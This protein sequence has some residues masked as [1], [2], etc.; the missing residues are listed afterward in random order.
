MIE[1]EVQNFQAI[2]HATMAVDGFAAIVGRSNIGKSAIVRA[3][4]IALTGAIG[5]DFVRHGQECD[6]KIRQTK[7]CKCFSKVVIR[8]S[9]MEITWEKGDAVS[10]YTVKRSGTEP[11]VYEGLERGTPE[12]LKEGFLPVKIGTRKELIQIPDQFEPIFLLN[13]SG[14]AVADVLSDVARLDA[15]N[16]AMGDANRDRK[17]A[18]SKRKVR[19]GDVAAL[20]EALAL[21]EGLDRVAVDSLVRDLK[22]A[23]TKN[24]QLSQ[25][26]GFI[27]R[28]GLLKTTMV[29]LDAVLKPELPDNDQLGEKGNQLVQVSE[30]YTALSEKVPGLRALA[31]M[32]KVEV[33]DEAPLD[34]THD[35]LLQ[36]DSFLRRLNALTVAEA[37]LAPAQHIDVPDGGA[38]G[39]TLI[40]LDK[41]DHW[42]KK[43]EA[44]EAALARVPTIAELPDFDLLQQKLTECL[45]Y[46]TLLED[47][48][49][50]AEVV[51]STATQIKEAEADETALLA[52]LEALGVCP[53]CDQPVGHSHRLHMEAQ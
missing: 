1:L 38:A 27:D 11:E 51:K 46:H 49:A 37:E 6:R 24:K 47:A 20:V 26:S 44:V 12:F 35:R 8:T 21:Y 52:E 23:G 3:A 34:T 13:Q 22:V 45:R 53:T 10:R 43:L 33:P 40:N 28:A 41:I 25:V 17:D 31:E 9:A 42:L 4:Q 39:S 14:P 16:Q 19:E 18:V 48:K 7:K 50:L 30:F 32:V 5:T 15:I 29:G 2:R 36:A